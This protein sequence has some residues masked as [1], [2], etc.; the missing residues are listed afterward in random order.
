MQPH[1][2]LRAE[3]KPLESRTAL[4]PEFAERL[5]AAGYALTVEACEQRA[6]PTEDYRS[7]GCSIA[8]PHSWKS[9]APQDTIVLGLKEL[10]ENDE[11]LKH[12][13][14]HFAH[15]YKNQK[16]WEDVLRRFKS[17]GGQLY[18]LEYL[19]DENGRRVAA[20]GYWAGYAGAALAALAWARKESGEATPLETQKPR[21]N[22]NVLVE[23][24]T[25]AIEKTG[26]RPKMMVIGALGRSGQGAVELGKAINA[27]VVEWDIEET[28][29]GGPFPEILE[30]D[31]FLNCVF[32]QKSI[33]PF[34]TTEMLQ[35]Q[36]HN[37]SVIC[38]VS[39]DPYGD[40][41]PLP[42]YNKCTTF[43]DPTLRVVDGDKPVDLISIDHLPSL[44]PVES[45]EDFCEQL[46]PYLL[47]LDQ[48]DDGV[49]GR[50]F[51]I[52]QQKSQL[53]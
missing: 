21:A 37:L 51:D 11:L 3:S 24:L 44:L 49:W 22:K 35:N 16:G 36:Q 2:W 33:P 23:E 14:I 4:T 8:E 47:K 7:L 50:A 31:I 18:D 48:L 13:H 39:C 52:F 9:E 34:V 5:I 53:V 27:D 6:I 42:I 26:K 19:V 32:I 28:K 40:Y 41:N 45:S 12:R 43:D 30:C 25:T 46:M 20:F 17:G 38:D 1:V 15:V 10:E 29:A